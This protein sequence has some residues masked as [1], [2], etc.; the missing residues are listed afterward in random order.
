M[1]KYPNLEAAHS[2]TKCP[3]AKCHYIHSTES[4]FNC[5]LSASQA[6]ELARNV[7]LK[8][9]LI[10]DYGQQDTDF[11]H[12]WAM[13]NSKSLSVGMQNKKPKE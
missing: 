6:I 8:A 13:K 12:L 9:Q 11:V 10:L 3:G 5:E 7:L 1:K 2:D 4:S